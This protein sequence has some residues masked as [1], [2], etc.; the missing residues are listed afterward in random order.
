MAIICNT[1]WSPWE[2]HEIMR[3]LQALRPQV[4]ES[5]RAVSVS[6]SGSWVMDSCFKVNL[7]AFVSLPAHTNQV[8]WELTTE[9]WDVWL[10]PWIERHF[11]FTLLLSTL[12]R[13]AHSYSFQA[14]PSCHQLS[15]G[16]G[17]WRLAG[18]LRSLQQCSWHS[19]KCRW[20]PGDA[21][22]PGEPGAGPRGRGAHVPCLG[23]PFPLGFAQ[24]RRLVLP[25]HFFWLEG[26][27]NQWFKRLVCCS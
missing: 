20:Q 18:Q 11:C 26:S 3:G 17:L 14:F 23:F 5:S 8:I 1:R 16:S 22:P 13:L 4:G 15:S 7:G 10:G 19:C 27:R 12:A 24:L 9:I 6:V 2:L 25:K 21:V